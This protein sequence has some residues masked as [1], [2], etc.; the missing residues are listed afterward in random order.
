MHGRGKSI[1]LSAWP[2]VPA[3]RDP[4]PVS[5]LRGSLKTHRCVYT[6]SLQKVH[7]KCDICLPHECPSLAVHTHTHT[8][9]H[10]TY[11]QTQTCTHSHICIH[12]DFGL[13]SYNQNR[14]ITGHLLQP[15]SS[16]LALP[17]PLKWDQLYLFPLCCL[18][19][20]I[21]ISQEEAS[22]TL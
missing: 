13:R 6:H 3:L 7:R 15:V 14:N 2:Q 10:P 18:L 19:A 22:C 1:L 5:R 20:R 9:M 17:T 16:S 21:K 8:H 12:T 4:S 11:A